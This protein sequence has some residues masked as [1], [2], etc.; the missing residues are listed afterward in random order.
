MI[1]NKDKKDFKKSKKFRP[2]KPKSEYDQKIIDI[3]RVTRVTA[4]GKRLRFRACVVIGD[5]KG[6]VGIGVKKGADVTIAINKAVEH[7]KKH[8]IEVKIVDDTIPHVIENKYKASIVL[9]KPAP[10]GTGIIAGGVV[11]AV[12]EL[13][14]IKN[15]VGKIK[16]SRNKINNVKST[17][18]AF[19]NLKTKEDFESIRK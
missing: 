13:A 1:E 10:T 6:K 18:E 5:K 3:A 2:R 9:L 12:A 16:G 11:R 7:A 19:T 14:G 17:L 4:G 8:L 15:I